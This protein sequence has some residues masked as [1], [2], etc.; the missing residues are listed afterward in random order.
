[1]TKPSKNIIIV[2]VIVFALILCIAFS[3]LQSLSKRIPDNA[4]GNTAGNLNNGG[5]FCESD[6]MVYFANPYDSNSLYSMTVE[7]DNLKFLNSMSVKYINA[8]GNYVFYFGKPSKVSSGL[9][10][11]VSKTGIF[12]IDKNGKK[13][14][15]ITNDVTQ[16]MLLVGNDI[17]YQKYTETEGA[18]F[19]KINIKKMDPEE[20]LSYMVNPAGYFQGKIYY[21]GMYSDHNLYAYDLKTDTESKV[22][23]Y[24]MWNPIFDGNNVYF[25]DIE[26]NYKLCKYNIPNDI[27]EVLTNDRIDFFNVYGDLIYYQTS[28][29]TEPALKRMRTDGSEKTIVASGTYSEVNI[30]SVYTYFSPFG[31]E[32][33]LYRTPT[34]GAPNV[35]EFTAAQTAMIE[36][37]K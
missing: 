5:L 28:S 22:W 11:V 18:T 12:Q 19:C 9:G 14:K 3:V 31:S 4:I 37:L 13:N 34:F 2:T 10:S 30:T 6:G 20:L 7:G 26:N 24:N 27:F 25:M 15:A 35:E 17:Y 21:N 36:R 29:S 1:M 32:Y 8:G 16:S 33:P 23:E